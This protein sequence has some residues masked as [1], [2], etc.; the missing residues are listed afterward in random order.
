MFTLS[1]Y[2]QTWRLKRSH[3]K[4]VMAA[5]HLNNRDAK[6]ELKV[7]NNDR[8]LPFCPS[9][10]WG[11][12]EQ[13]AHVLSPFNGITQKLS[14]CITLLERLV[15]SGWGAGVK[16]LCTAALSLVYSTAEYCPSVWCHSTHICLID[17][18]LNDAMPIVTGPLC[19]TPTDHLPIILGIQPAELC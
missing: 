9:P 16:T 18:V 12:T 2:L 10:T 3:T 13:I 19:P 4:L 8:L 5:F 6:H 17:S 14:L 7:Y 1:T 15:V 11:K